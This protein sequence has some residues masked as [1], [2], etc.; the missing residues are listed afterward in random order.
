MDASDNKIG[1]A[2]AGALAEG[3]K[4]MTNLK[5]L[6]LYSEYCMDYFVC[7]M[8]VMSWIKQGAG[9]CAHGETGRWEGQ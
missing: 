7:E 6:N 5:E 9:W 2:G 4:E 8:A 1:A 3:L